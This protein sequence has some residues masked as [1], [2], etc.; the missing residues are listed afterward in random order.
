[1]SLHHGRRTF[2]YLHSNI[3]A[4]VLD[5][6]TEKLLAAYRAFDM[7]CLRK[8]ANNERAWR[9]SDMPSPSAT[10]ELSRGRRAAEHIT[11]DVCYAFYSQKSNAIKIG[12]TGQLLKRWASLETASG[13]PLQLLLIWRTADSR[14]LE[15]LLFHRY[16]AHRGIGEW[17]EADRTLP[18]LQARFTQAWQ[19]R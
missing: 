18:D 17:F 3:S 19:S 15:A 11:G 8:L 13:M 2:V 9:D 5:G 10:N 16:A 12:R 1:M 14:D 7:T 4:A 6:R